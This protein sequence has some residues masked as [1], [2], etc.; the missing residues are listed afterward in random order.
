MD[1]E[2][3]DSNVPIKSCGNDCSNKGDD[4]GG[5][6][7]SKWTK[8]LIGGV[9][10]VLSLKGIDEDAKEHVEEEDEGLGKDHSLPK[11][12]RSTHF[13]HEFDEKHGTAVTV[14][15]LHYSNYLIGEWKLNNG[16]SLHW[17]DGSYCCILRD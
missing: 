16:S 3:L 5:G 12:P 8:A 6:L 11:I 13:R 2:N 17:R 14:D 10:S 9:D 15:Y 4:V 7:P 1:V